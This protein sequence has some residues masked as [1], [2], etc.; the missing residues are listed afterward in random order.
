MKGR[1]VTVKKNVFYETKD[2]HVTIW[3]I[4]VHCE[5]QYALGK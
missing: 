5:Y 2:C 1:D 4:D 3:I